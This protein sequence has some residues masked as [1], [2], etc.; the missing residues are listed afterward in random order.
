M[1]RVFKVVWNDVRGTY[2]VCDENKKSRGKPKSVKSAVMAAAVATLFGLGGVA[3]A[4]DGPVDKVV[5]NGNFVNVNRTEAS[6]NPLAA[7]ISVTQ[8]DTASLT[9]NNSVFQDNKLTLD[10]TVGSPT[11]VGVASIGT[12]VTV[13]S[14]RFTNNSATLSNLQQDA[15][16]IYGSAI[17]VQNANLTVDKSTFDGNSAITGR[18]TQGSAIYQSGGQIAVTG[19]SF[20]NNVGQNN[21][22]STDGNVTGG[23]VSLWGVRGTIDGTTFSGNT[24]VTKNADDSAL[25]DNIAYGGAVYSRSGI[26]GGD[27]ATQLTVS[28]ST[29]TGNSVQGGANNALGGAIY[30]KGDTNAD[31][32]NSFTHQLTVQNSKFESNSSTGKGGA[33]YALNAPVTISDGSTFTKNTAGNGGGAVYIKNTVN[34]V[35]ASTIENATFSENSVGQ[36]GSAAALGIA[37]ATVNVTGSTFENN[38]ADAS[39]VYVYLSSADGK[40]NNLQRS[41]ANITSSQF[42]G[43]KSQAGGAISSM[44]DLSVTDSTFTGNVASNDADGDGGGALF[45]GAE[46]KTVIA[47]S[48]FDKNQSATAG[49]GA[50][51]TRKGNVANN[52]G[53]ALDITDSVFTGNTAA[54]NGGAIRNSFYTS[55]QNSAAVTIAGTQFEGNSASQSG[56]AIYNDGVTDQAG[57]TASIAISDSSFTGNTATQAGGAIYNGAGTSMEFSG[58][59]TFSGNTAG[60]VANDIHNLGAITVAGG[61]TTLDGGISG[62]TGTIDITGGTLKAP[63]SSGAGQVSINGGTLE[64]AVIGTNSNITINRGVLQTGSDQV[65]QTALNDAGDNTAAGGLRSDVNIAYSGG[66]L[67]LTDARYNLDYASSL[68]DLIKGQQDR[69]TSL[70]MLGELNGVQ[71]GKINISE[72]NNIGV[73]LANVDVAVDPQQGKTS[74]LVVG[75]ATVPGGAGSEFTNAT[76]HDNDLGARTLDLGNDGS[77]VMITGDHALTLVGDGNALIKTGTANTPVTVEV[78]NGTVANDFDTAGTLNLGTAAAANGGTLNGSVNVAA[79]G[80]VNVVGNEYTVSQNVVSSGAVN[81]QN[82]ATLNADGVTL[83]DSGALNVSGTLNTNN[84]TGNADSMITVGDRDSAGA[85]YAGNVSL[86][87]GMM[88]FDPAWKDGVGVEGASQGGVVFNNAT[89]DGTVAVG[90]NSLAVLGEQSTDWA[91]AEF[92]RTGRTWSENGITAALAVRAPMTLGANG[93]ITVDGSKTAQDFQTTRPVANTANFADNSMLMVDAGALN[94][95]AAITS[96]GG[97]ATVA[98]GAALHVANLNVNGTATILDGFTGGAT[99]TADIAEG[100][101]TGNNLTT[102]D[103]MINGLELANTGGTVTV[104]ATGVNRAEDVFPGLMPVNIMNSIWQNGQNDINSANPGVAFLSRASDNRYIARSDAARQIN[105]ATQI[106]VAAGTQ[107]ATVQAVDAITGALDNHLSLTSNISQ[108]GAPLLHKEGADLWASVL[109]RNTDSGSLKAGNF[110]SNYDN[111]FGGI[112][113][114][115]DYTG[116]A[117]GSEK[118]RMG[119]ALSYGKGDSKSKGD[120]NHTKNDYD[121]YGASIYGGWNNENANLVIDVGYMKGD[122]DLKQ[123]MSDALGGKLKADVDTKV[124]TAGVKAEYRVPTGAMDV[125]PHI[126]ARYINLKTD[127]FDTHNSLGKLFRTDSETQNLWQFPI[128]VTFSGNYLS[129]DGWT[130]KPK[131]DVSVIPVSGDKD[132][133]TSVRVP[134]VNAVDSATADMMDNLSWRGMLGLEVQKGNTSFGL[135]AGYQKS[136]D[137]KSRGVML[138][139]GHQFD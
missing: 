120:F 124:W 119:V 100:G 15:N 118:Y 77:G 136:D 16:G 47:K 79:N 62:D 8:E 67:A 35:G 105:G 96:T 18:Q 22:A 43:N 97:T 93:A 33:I 108:P 78:G 73:V 58:N 34:G 50:I 98:G 9:V 101:W 81:V 113:V 139:F 111:D 129:N 39:A 4:A 85:L 82:G 25:V 31:A 68:Q 69:N 80:T 2:M 72:L 70:V 71:D 24:A 95:Q 36:G 94:N 106:A 99:G 126:G 29:F 42:T 28:N 123:D 10:N 51:D 63:M 45:L 48:T 134:G 14:S 121:T 46:S 6:N 64:S 135:Q 3:G 133:K 26:W 109:Y 65:A 87:G 23:A 89:V 12:N 57:N 138:S 52:T 32:D 40:A 137:A 59:N 74:N 19:S 75:A 17:G 91:K 13:N 11:A 27:K 37:N 1:N 92:A 5:D 103:A 122:N 30:V 116:I 112:I 41:E 38:T 115:T 76:T 84:L 60:G 90:R 83:N 86:N 104:R 44:E 132:V 49:G 66:S 128:G 20:T 55:S 125:T 7:E 114:G 107:A 117:T 131:L 110:S 88:V 127:A 102:T 56:G 54:E 61:L 130:V 53:A 21:S